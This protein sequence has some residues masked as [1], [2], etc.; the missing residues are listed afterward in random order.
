VNRYTI[1]RL[2]KEEESGNKEEIKKVN[3]AKALR[4]VKTVKMWK[5]QKGNSQDL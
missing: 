1:A 5:L 3:T 2:V 4:A